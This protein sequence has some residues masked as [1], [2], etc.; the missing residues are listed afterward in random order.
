MHRALY[1]SPTHWGEVWDQDAFVPAEDL[2]E[3]GS[4]LM[5]NDNE[6]VMSDMSGSTESFLD[7]DNNLKVQFINAHT[8]ETL[9][10]RKLDVSFDQ[11]QEDEWVLTEDMW[12]HSCDEDK[13]QSSKDG[14]AFDRETILRNN[15]EKRVDEKADEIK[16]IVCNSISQVSLFLVTTGFCVSY[17]FMLDVKFVLQI[18]PRHHMKQQSVAEPTESPNPHY[19]TLFK[20]L[21]PL[22]PPQI[23]QPSETYGRSYSEEESKQEKEENNFSFDYQ[24]DLENHVGPSPCQILQA[25]TMSN[26]ND[27]LN[28]ERLETIGDSFLKY[29]ITS[30]LFCTFENIHEGKLSHLRS[31]QVISL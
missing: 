1:G 30:Y 23:Y 31:K 26:A 14:D 15:F 7:E 25:M 8:A 2:E 20:V 11:R 21:T 24:P 10:K 5:D 19:D 27:G 17:E 28:L 29:A 16:D 6:S 4:N 18:P 22:C 12:W 3:S 13:L 9:D